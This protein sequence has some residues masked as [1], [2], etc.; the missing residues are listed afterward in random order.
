MKNKNF[1]LASKSPRR[2]ELLNLLEIDFTVI[3]SDIVEDINGDLTNEEVVMNLAY[4]KAKEIS[5]KNE[6]T[7]VLGFDTLVIVDG[8]PLGKPRDKED[9]YRMLRLL[10]DR[11]HRVLTG[12]AIVNG[13]YKDCFYSFADVTFNNVSDEEIQT[14]IATDE[15]FDK[16]GSYGIQGYGSKHIKEIS[17][18]YFA[19]VGLPISKL[20]NKLKSL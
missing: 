11:T 20:Y 4:Q 8:V 5:N 7:F 9:A 13:D 12:C 18:D 14:Y 10:N 17:G 6:D 19:I 15:P 1:I 2:I 3:P 16:A